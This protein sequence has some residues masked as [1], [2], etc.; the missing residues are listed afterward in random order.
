MIPPEGIV[1]NPDS[2]NPFREQ[3]NH[4]MRLVETVVKPDE[5]LKI[6]EVPYV[7][8]KFLPLSFDDVLCSSD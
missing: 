5:N 3:T 2:T 6:T 1:P 8:D 7:I 4:G